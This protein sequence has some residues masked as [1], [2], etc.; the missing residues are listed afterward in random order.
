[1]HDL[2]HLFQVSKVHLNIAKVVLSVTMDKDVIEITKSEVS[3]LKTPCD[4]KRLVHSS[5][6]VASLDILIT[7]HSGYSPL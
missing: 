4:Y 5:I 7:C 2:T 1:M 3:T 6:L